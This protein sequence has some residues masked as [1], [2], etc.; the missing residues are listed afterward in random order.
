MKPRTLAVHAG[1][2]PDPTTGAIMPPI[3]MTSTFVQNTPGETKGYDYTRAG[4]PNFTQLETLLAALENGKYATVFSAGLAALSALISTLKS[5]DEVIALQGLY[6]GTFR[7]FN[8]IFSN[9]G[10]RFSQIPKEDLHKA[11]KAKPH[12]LLFETP[13]N[14]LLELYD[15]KAISA[16]AHQEGVKVI[17]DNTFATPINQTPL[18]EG[19]D[20]VWHSTTKYLGGHSD[21]IGGALI[22]DSLELKQAFD[23]ARK[24]MGLNPSPFD[25][26]LTQ[27]GVKTLP[28]RMKAHNEN[29]Q[30]LS[31]WLSKH[32]KV[33]RV[34]YPRTFG[35]SRH[36]KSLFSGTFNGWSY[37]TDLGCRTS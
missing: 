31:A 2:E 4:N 13:T 37:R 27:R 18:K 21:V 35:F 16:L 33:K 34:Y 9:F 12:F 7:L 30:K 6:G 32:P 36:P 23:F 25:V 24:S 19:A 3:Y 10:I 14:P 8:S 17:V 1:Q 5:G 20:I 29:G 26:W 28:L 11:L 22:T 15:I